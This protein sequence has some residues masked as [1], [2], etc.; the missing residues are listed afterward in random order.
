MCLEKCDRLMELAAQ[1]VTASPIEHGGRRLARTTELL[2][3]KSW[4]ASPYEAVQ[5]IDVTL[6][7]RH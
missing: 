5:V 2:Q 7:G 3:P 1:T 6:I 4:C